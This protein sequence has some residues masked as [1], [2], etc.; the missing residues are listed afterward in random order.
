[1]ALGQKKKRTKRLSS[2]AIFL[3]AFVLFVTVFGG[4]CLW[5]VV[6]INEQRRVGAGDSSSAP[7]STDPAATFTEEDA[8]NLFLVTVDTDAQGFIVVRTDPAN[9]RI[10]TLAIPRETTVDVGT[11]QTRMFEL[12]A[13]GG[14]TATRDAAAKLLGMEFQNYAVLTYS[15]TEK[16]LK[17]LDGGLIFTLPE[18]LDYQN[19][20][21]GATLKLTGGSRNLTPSQVVD[22]MRYPN[23]HGG[24]KQQADIQAQLTAALINQYMKADGHGG[25]FQQPHRIPANRHQG[26]PFRQGEG[27]AAVSG[28]TEHGR[29]LFERLLRGAICGQRGRPALRAGGQRQGQPARDLRHIL[30]NSP[31][32]EGPAGK[33]PAYSPWN[34]APSRGIVKG[35]NIDLEVLHR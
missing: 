29:H 28:G 33:S 35:R 2:L 6:K 17:K 24:R 12:Y 31:E 22:V 10:R 4:L 18:D 25:G 11:S 34:P 9:T 30:K 5:A 3:L 15:N 16:L 1:M 27:G 7:I 32:S 13:S 20:S 21:T 19:P 14:A 23:W 8:R 26:L